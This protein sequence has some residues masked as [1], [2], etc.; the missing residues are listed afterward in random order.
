MALGITQFLWHVSRTDEDHRVPLIRITDKDYTVPLTG[1]T[2]QK[3]TQN[4]SG[5]DFW[6]IT[7]RINTPGI[8]VR[9]LT[10]DSSSDICYYAL[11]RAPT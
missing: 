7:Q 4:L 1:I 2:N 10:V 6:T 3:I 5:Q 11:G 9:A 8:E